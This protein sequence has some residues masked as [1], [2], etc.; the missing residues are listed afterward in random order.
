MVQICFQAVKVKLQISAINSIWT[1]KPTV[2]TTFKVCKYIYIGLP[3]GSVV[4]NLPA[5]VGD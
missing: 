4:K 3:G 2:E 1:Q 5:N